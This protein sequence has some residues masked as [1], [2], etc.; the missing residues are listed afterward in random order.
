MSNSWFLSSQIRPS[1]GKTRQTNLES[2]QSSKNQGDVEVDIG[3]KFEKNLLQDGAQV[4]EVKN[5]A[6][7][8]VTKRLDNLGASNAITESVMDGE[9]GDIISESEVIVSFSSSSAKSKY[10]SHP[11][12]SAIGPVHG[13]VACDR[14]IHGSSNT[15]SA[16]EKSTSDQGGDGNGG[17]RL[18]HSDCGSNVSGSFGPAYGKNACDRG[19]IGPS[20]S[21]NISNR[22]GHDKSGTGPT[23]GRDRVDH[24]NI[25]FGPADGRKISGYQV[26]HDKSGFGPTDGKRT[27]DRVD[28]DKIG[29]EPTDGKKTF[30][31][32][33][34][35][36]ISI[37]PSDGKKTFDR[38]DHDKIGIGP[39]DG[40]KTFDRVDHDK[41]GIGP[42]DGKKAFHRVDHDS[43]SIGPS[44]GLKTFDRVDH[45]II[46][47][48]PSDGKKTFDRVDHDKIGIGLTD[49]KKTFDRV[50]HDKIGIGPTDGEKT[51]DRVDHDK[52]GI[53]PT[54]G[55]KAFHRVDHDS[56]SI[57]P[58]D[59][60]KTFDRVDHDKIGLGP[61]DGK[62]ACHRVDHDSISIGSSDGKKTFDRLDH[63]KIGIG[64]SDGITAFHRVDH[65][66]ISIGPSDGKKACCRDDHDKGSTRSANGKSPFDCAF[67]AIESIGLADSKV[68]C[69]H[70]G[71]ANSTI[72][73]AYDNV[74]YDL[75][76]HASSR[77][78]SADDRNAC[79]LGG[80]G[81]SSIRTPDDKG[82]FGYRGDVSDGI[83]FVHGDNCDSGGE[84]SSDVRYAGGKDVCYL[85]EGDS[86]STT[87]E[88]G[89]DT[90]V[91]CGNDSG[92]IW[93]TDSE[94]PFDNGGGL[95]DG[96][97]SSRHVIA[98]CLADVTSE[99][100]FYLSDIS[101][102]DDDYNEVACDSFVEEYSSG[103]GVIH[104]FEERVDANGG[105]AYYK[106]F[107]YWEGHGKVIN[108]WNDDD[109]E[110]EKDDDNDDDDDDDD[111]EGDEEEDVYEEEKEGEE[112]DYWV[113]GYEDDNYLDYPGVLVD[114]AKNSQIE[115]I[116]LCP[117]S[118]NY[119][120]SPVPL[121]GPLLAFTDEGNSPGDF[122][123]S[124]GACN[125]DM[126]RNSRRRPKCQLSRRK[127]ENDL[128]TQSCAKAT[129]D[130]HV[131][132]VSG[133]NETTTKEGL[134][135]YI[136]VLSGGEVKGITMM[137]QGNALVTISTQV[138]GL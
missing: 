45:D 18:V 23:D 81:S 11:I 74:V 129:L 9:K 108:C 28:H 41:I 19:G 83:E 112:E 96:A 58:T 104:S 85:I 103:D 14:F 100:A 114:S 78:G 47:I 42:S 109:E 136:E 95:V 54:D 26:D 75:V 86:Y 39:S 118:A 33:D 90:S 138:Q 68:V 117:F 1:R 113:E 99:E 124:K 137:K 2:Y 62:K 55:K 16:D 72:G 98:D 94:D 91:A 4:H 105:D 10:A 120:R 64:P 79:D 50:D 63:D 73:Y 67:Q 111:D 6:S 115:S 53:E 69:T 125:E 101:F 97:H 3:G 8:S 132:M 128:E 37:G 15:V 52:I 44:D 84:V 59:G 70:V 21:T 43:I 134:L 133:L 51:F 7:C 110:E 60:K 107:D 27:S 34:H 17:I 24:D 13:S 31:R 32:V 123:T 20:D 130:E 106:Y 135:N 92:G 48:G 46:S 49:G 102:F 12:D 93:Y 35:D 5:S 29:I 88:S 89:D 121:S 66:N 38:V 61:S 127:T 116:N 82:A 30:D 25:V 57:G 65:A 36:S 76:S 22:V 71:Q 80:H 77:D 126:N 119:P 40:K 122:K 87:S 131:L 56:I